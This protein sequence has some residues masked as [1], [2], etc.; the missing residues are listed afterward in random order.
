MATA[1]RATGHEDD[2]DDEI[3]RRTTTQQPTN[4]RRRGGGGSTTAR[5]RRQLG[6]DEQ[7]IKQLCPGDKNLFLGQNC[8]VPF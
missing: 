5:G 8:F 2:G 3:G 6:E 4:E 7:K 1:R